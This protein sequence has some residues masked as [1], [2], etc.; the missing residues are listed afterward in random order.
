[1]WYTR[2]KQ[3]RI[4]DLD[5]EHPYNDDYVSGAGDNDDE[6]NANNDYVS[7]V[8]DHDQ[9]SADNVRDPAGGAKDP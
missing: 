3:D 6:R 4:S 8:R 5:F 2:A 7:D 1:M 9:R